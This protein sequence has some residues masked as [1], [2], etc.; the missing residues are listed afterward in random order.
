MNG[1]LA[2]CP[3][4]RAPTNF[5]EK[6]DEVQIDLN[7]GI[8]EASKRF[9]SCLP[10]ALCH[11]HIQSCIPSRAAPRF[12]NN[13]ISSMLS[14]LISS[15]SRFDTP[16]KSKE[17][18]LQWRACGARIGRSGACHLNSIGQVSSPFY[19]MRV[20]IMQKQDVRSLNPF[21]RKFASALKQRNHHI[22]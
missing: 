12:Y 20:N 21:W 8:L 4:A 18:C 15:L 2:P 13:G 11:L 6:T 19:I 10:I 5:D 9:F 7:C 17:R 22:R 16:V 14:W 1:K 3:V